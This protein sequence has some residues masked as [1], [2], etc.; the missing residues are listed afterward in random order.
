MFFLLPALPALLTT[1][2]EATAIVLAARVAN[3]AYDAVVNPKDE[4]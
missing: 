4:K 2:A 3:D 1:I